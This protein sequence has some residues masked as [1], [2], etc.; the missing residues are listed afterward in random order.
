MR[1]AT[2][3]ESVLDLKSASYPGGVGR[4]WLLIGGLGALRA[5]ACPAKALTWRAPRHRQ[6][7]GTGRGM[8]AIGNFCHEGTD[9]G[10]G[11]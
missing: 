1:H 6:K 7:R 10:G 9:V 4:I 8:R 5:I 11:G 3:A 2:M